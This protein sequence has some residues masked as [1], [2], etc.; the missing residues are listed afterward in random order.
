MAIPKEEHV[1]NEA[2]LA[3]PR[4]KSDQ[5]LL[6]VECHCGLT[7]F[8]LSI[9]S[10]ALPLKSAICHCDSCRHATGQLFATFAV[11]PVESPPKA[12]MDN[13]KLVRYESSS[14]CE[15]WFCKRCGASVLNVDKN[16]EAVEWEV[17]T[18]VLSFKDGLEGK[19][20]RVQL[21]VEDVGGDG[22]AAV[23][24]NQGR[25][26]GMDRHLRGRQSELISDDM[27]KDMS[28]RKSVQPD[29]SISQENDRLRA[30]C[31]CGNIAL[32]IARPG[33]DFNNGSGKFEA[34]LD[35]CTSCRRVSGFE[36]TSWITLQPGLIRTEPPSLHDFLA[37]RTKAAH[38]QTS[39]DVSRYFC[40]KCGATIFYHKHNL[41]TIDVAVGLLDTGG[42]GKARAEDWLEWQRYP[43][44]LSYQEDAI[45]KVFVANL[46]EGMRL[47]EAI[48][49]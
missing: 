49:G 46:A 19:L 34:N 40:V 44:C 13:D 36:I 43:N 20:N 18:G 29:T 2:H 7:S 10:S 3:E 15:R 30:R 17:G 47:A 23:W 5:C 6:T 1:A 28:E 39:T 4:K 32:S 41:D 38:Y 24:I 35:A 45:D 37:D 9:P 31:H 22:G 48:W 27:L 25:L 42:K 11:L 26:A 14:V 33:E 16:D 8:P 12:V 21:W